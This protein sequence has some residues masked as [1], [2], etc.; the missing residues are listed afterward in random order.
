MGAKNMDDN[1]LIA[2][3]RW[4]FFRRN[5]DYKKKWDE[6]FRNPEIN[7][8][9]ILFKEF[10]WVNFPQSRDWGKSW[11]EIDR[12]EEG[13]IWSLEWENEDNWE[14]IKEIMMARLFDG[15]FSDSYSIN[16]IL[17]TKIEKIEGNIYILSGSEN[18]DPESYFIQTE[19]APFT[20]FSLEK[21]PNKLEISINNFNALF[22]ESSQRQHKFL[23][24]VLSKIAE[25][26]RLWIDIA[27]K[28][29]NDK[30]SRYRFDQY[31]NYLKIWDLVQL[32][33]RRWKE[34]AKIIYPK[35]N[36]DDYEGASKR[37]QQNYNKAIEFI[38]NPRLF[39]ER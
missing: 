10:G 23:D 18:K 13:T 24:Y 31:D 17:A 12:I 35:D 39:T 33:G 8:L 11:D 28:I 6:Y 15:A 27:N 22:Y 1:L 14:K 2:K 25:Q 37:A 3:Y 30:E 34:I 5:E 26:F 16:P 29:E 32:K 21:I 38:N 19:N 9:I 4:E 36:R 7:H 20:P